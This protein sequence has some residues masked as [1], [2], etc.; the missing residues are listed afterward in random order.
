MVEKNGIYRCEICGNIISVIEAHD[1]NIICCGQ[2]MILLKEKTTEQEGKEKHVPVIEIK[3]DKIL[4][5]VGSIKH[6]MEDDHYI[7]LIQLIKN[8]K[9]IAEKRLYPG[10]EPETTF[11]IKDTE[12]IK[13]RE[14]C[15]KHGLWIN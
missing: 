5:K 6:P 2:E 15:N 14:I 3:E 1:P 10:E 13:A 8:N 7:E 9:V 11:C 4:I 12:G